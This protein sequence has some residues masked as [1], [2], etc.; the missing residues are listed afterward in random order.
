VAFNDGL[1]DSLA[2]L[3]NGMNNRDSIT[4]FMKA[5]NYEKMTL[6]EWNALVKGTS[7]YGNGD[8]D[9]FMMG[10]A[11]L[12]SDLNNLNFAQFYKNVNSGMKFFHEVQKSALLK[13]YKY[14]TGKSLITSRKAFFIW[15]MDKAFVGSMDSVRVLDAAVTLRNEYKSYSGLFNALINNES[16]SSRYQNLLKE[17]ANL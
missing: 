4:E 11:M 8:D 10:T 16:A 3:V 13:G 1:K 6:K 14:G 17:S 15:A 12:N 2:E 9:S 7:Y 5:V